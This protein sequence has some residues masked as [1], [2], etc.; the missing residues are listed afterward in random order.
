MKIRTRNTN[1]FG[2]TV[3]TICGAIQFDKNGVAEVSKEVGDKLYEK[4]LSIARE[5]EPFRELKRE[6]DPVDTVDT[7]EEEK[8]FRKLEDARKKFQEDFKAFQEE[9]ESFKKE[10]EE[11][12]HYRDTT[13]GLWATDRPLEDFG[14]EGVQLEY[15]R[16]LGMEN[17]HVDPP[18]EI[19]QKEEVKKVILGMKKAELL[20]YVEK[21]GLPKEEW[22]KLNAEE[23][24]KYAISKL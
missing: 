2:K 17:V 1:R 13:V 23:L 6:E 11:L 10:L 8:G 18:I 24:K 22:E 15:F 3:L 19:D 4:D 20:E 5:D 14:I 9:K 16:R 21:A 12:R 7:A